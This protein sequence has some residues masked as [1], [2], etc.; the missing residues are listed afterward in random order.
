[1]CW[2]AVHPMFKLKLLS[3]MSNRADHNFLINK[4]SRKG[5]HFNRVTDHLDCARGNL[6]SKIW[7]TDHL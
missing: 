4:F 3:A 5:T 7:R 1:M 2:R 6:I